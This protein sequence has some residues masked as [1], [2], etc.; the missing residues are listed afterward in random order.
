[1]FALPSLNDLEDMGFPRERAKKALELFRDF[2]QILNYLSQDYFPEEMESI[3]E[4]PPPKT[5]QKSKEFSSYHDFINE[6]RKRYTKDPESARTLYRSDKASPQSNSSFTNYSPNP[7]LNLREE[8]IPIGLKNVGNTCFLN[9]LL[10]TY[11]MLPSFRNEIL[12]FKPTQK[13]WEI[14][15]KEMKLSKDDLIHFL[16]LDLIHEIQ[17]LFARQLLSNYKAVDPKHAIEKV[18]DQNGKQFHIGNQHDVTE[19]NDLFWKRIEEGYFVF[20]DFK[21]WKEKEEKKKLRIKE[22]R[23]RRQKEKE[24]EK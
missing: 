7:K 22:I 5:H 16:P 13:E 2:D 11:F 4:K 9:S 24:K 10:Q 19:F 3:P 21:S 18:Q 17:R 23:K 20:E 14:Q 6:Y 8:L 12:K 1:M 15:K